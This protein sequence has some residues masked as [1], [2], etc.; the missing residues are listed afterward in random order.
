MCCKFAVNVNM[1][2]EG[3]SSHGW[4]LWGA[5]VLYRCGGIRWGIGSRGKGKEG[6]GAEV[7]SFA[8]KKVLG[9]DDTA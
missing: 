8:G 3:L 5:G 7:P 9:A 2:L 1:Q 4:R 6:G